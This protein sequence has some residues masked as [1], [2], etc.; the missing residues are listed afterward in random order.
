M[1]SVVFSVCLA[2]M[3]AILGFMVGVIHE[4]DRTNPPS[5]PRK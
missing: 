4:R 2:V 1:V 3:A 5:D